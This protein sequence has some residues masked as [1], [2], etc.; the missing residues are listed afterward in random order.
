M[1][2]KPNEWVSISDLMSGVMAVVML[3]LVISVVQR[4]YAEMKHK[5]ELEQGE[6]AK[7]VK[8]TKMLT[9][10][11]SSLNQQG[12]NELIDFNVSEARVTLK[13]GAFERVSACITPLAK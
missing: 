7:R 4:T 12:M 9:D 5:Q 8:V 13:D 2:D 1:K 3:L 10:L 6:N 11:K